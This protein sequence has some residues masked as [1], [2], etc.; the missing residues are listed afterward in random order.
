MKNFEM[1]IEFENENITLNLED[2]FSDNSEDW[3]DEQWDIVFDKVNIAIW[4]YIESAKEFSYGSNKAPFKW[5]RTEHNIL[6]QEKPK[7]IERKIDPDT[8]LAIDPNCTNGF[9]NHW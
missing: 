3:S 1:W 4:K 7:W 6:K 2:S 5:K 9:P 8:G